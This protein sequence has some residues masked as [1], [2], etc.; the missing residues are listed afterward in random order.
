MDFFFLMF[1]YFIILLF[2][3]QNLKPTTMKTKFIFLL[4]LVA[5]GIPA[6]STIHTIIIVNS[7]FSPSNI[8]I[9]EGDTVKFQMGEFHNAVEVTKNTYDLNGTAS[10]GG[11]SIPFGGGSVKLSVAGTYYYVCTNHVGSGMKGIITVSSNSGTQ[12]DLVENSLNWLNVYPNPA[13]EVAN[14]QIKVPYMGQISVELIDISGKKVQQLI[15]GNFPEGNYSHAVYINR[16]LSEGRY[17]VKYTSKNK[18]FV[19]PLL[20]IR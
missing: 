18:V 8:S 4:F 5:I 12:V 1:N 20:I 9:K 14:L 15:S 13:N 7:S 6:N 19:Q 17:F 11:F 10:I 16:K 2:I 3:Y